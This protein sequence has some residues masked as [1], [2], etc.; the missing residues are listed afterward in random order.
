MSKVSETDQPELDPV[1]VFSDTLFSHHRFTSQIS[2][3]TPKWAQESLR[4]STRSNASP[5]TSS[6]VVQKRPA[7]PHVPLACIAFVNLEGQAQQLPTKMINKFLRR[8]PSPATFISKTVVP[9]TTADSTCHTSSPFKMPPHPQDRMEGM[10][11]CPCE[12]RG[13]DPPCACR[14]VVACQLV[15]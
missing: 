7:C 13:P 14:L 4:S 9:M 11:V 1:L 2:I 3:D 15:A 12:E 5:M 6:L 8:R 10:V